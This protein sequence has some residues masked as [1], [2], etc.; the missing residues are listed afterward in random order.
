MH[1]MGDSTVLRYPLI[2]MRNSDV[3]IKGQNP[4]D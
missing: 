3:K 4:K 1:F 2:Q